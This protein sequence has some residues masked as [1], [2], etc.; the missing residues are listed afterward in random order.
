MTDIYLDPDGDLLIDQDGGCQAAV[1]WDEARQ[2]IERYLLTC[3]QG[4]LY[5]GLPAPADYIFHPTWGVGLPRYEG[6]L[7]IKS[8]QDKMRD[9]TYQA[10][11]ASPVVAKNP[12]PIV[13]LSSP[14][15]FVFAVYVDVVL[16]DGTPGTI[17]VQ[18]TK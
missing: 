15:P 6:T 18:V 8:Q 1:G 11:L 17:A 14:A 4:V 2:Y 10:V 13:A 3:P 9:V 5:N 12:Q 7:Q 16:V